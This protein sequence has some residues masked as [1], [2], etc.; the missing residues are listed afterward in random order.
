MDL[1]QTQAV[2]MAYFTGLGT[3][4]VTE[5]FSDDVTWTTIESG[6]DVRGPSQVQE[7]IQGLHARM[8]DMQTRRLTISDDSA[9]VEGSCA[10]LDGSPRRVSYCVAYDL[11]DHRITSMRAYGALTPFMPTAGTE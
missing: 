5:Y 11:A 3:G 10:G 9:Y 2:M 6:A 4:H 7:A 8:T 1:E